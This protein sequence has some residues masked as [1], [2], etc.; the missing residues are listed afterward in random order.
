MNI[1]QLKEAEFNDIE[2]NAWMQKKRSLLSEAGFSGKEI[3]EYFGIK[4]FDRKALTDELTNIFQLELEYLPEKEEPPE[5]PKEGEK[6]KRKEPGIYPEKEPSWIQKF[7][8]I[9]EPAWEEKRAQAT[10]AVEAAEKTGRRPYEFEPTTEEVI[11][12]GF[13]ASVTGLLATGKVPEPLP[14]SAEKYMTPAQRILMQGSTLLGDL[15]FMTMG[16]LIG[17]G[18]GPVTAVGGVFALPA[19]LRKVLMDKY[20][21]G[22]IHSFS[23]FWKRLTDAVWETAKGEITGMATGAVGVRV[24]GLGRVPAE[25][26]TM[27]TVGDALEGQIPEPREFIDGAILIGGMRFS[28]HIAGKLRNIYWRSGKKPAEVIEDIKEDPSIKEDLFSDNKDVPD[29]YKAPEKPKLKRRFDIG[30]DTYEM[31]VGDEIKIVK[32]T[33]KGL[34]EVK[35][36]PDKYKKPEPAK[37]EI[38]KQRSDWDISR[39]DAEIAGLERRLREGEITKDVTTYYK[40]HLERLKAER[41]LLAELPTPE[42]VKPTATFRGWQETAEGDHIALYN[43]EGGKLDKSTV[44]LKTLKKEGIEVPETPEKPKIELKPPIEEPAPELKVSPEDQKLIGKF[45]EA[46][47]KLTSQIKEKREPAISKQALTARRARIA[48]SMAAD[49]DRLEQ[50]QNVMNGMADAIENRTLP[51]SL[52]GVT[53]KAQIETLRDFRGDVYPDINAINDW[54]ATQ[55]KRIKSA[56]IT[57]LEE[58]KQAQADIQAF[59]KGPS[60]EVLREKALKAKEAEFIGRKVPGFFP[61]PEPVGKMMVD[62]A[63]IEAGTTVL[64]PSAGMGNLAEVIRGAHPEA[65]LSV[66][67]W[68]YSLR[69]LLELK[70]FKVIGDDF[71]KHEGKYDRI[72]QNPPFEKGQDVDHVYHA[73]EHLN[74]GGRLI[75][76]MSEGPFFKTDKKSEAFRKWFEERKGTTYELEGAFKGAESFRQ[77]GVKS[78]IVMIDKPVEKVEKVPEKPEPKITGKPGAILSDKA[79]LLKEIDE[80]IKKAPEEATDI[81]WIKFKIDGATAKIAPW[82]D[83]L[84]EFR[85]RIQKTPEKEKIVKPALRK[86]PAKPSPVAAKREHI[87]ELIKLENAAGWFSDGN[88]IIKGEPPKNKKFT[89]FR[90]SADPKDVF[91]Q[92]DYDRTV[93]TERLYYYS[94]GIETLDYVVSKEPVARLGDAESAGVIFKCGD[95]YTAYMQD[96]FNVVRNRFPDAEYRVNPEDGMLVAYKDQKPVAGLMPFKPLEETKGPLYDEPP[97]KA[98]AEGYGLLSTDTVPMA[99]APEKGFRRK[100]EPPG[101]I[102]K[103]IRR[104]D[105]VNFL[106]EKLDVPIRTGRFWGA[107]RRYL[108]IFKLKEEVVRTKFAN[109][110]ET[111]CHEAGHGLQKFLWPEALTRQGLSSKPLEPWRKELLPIATKPRGGQAKLPEGFAEFIRLYVT[112]EKQALEKAPEFYKA[113]ESMLGE[114]SPEAKEILLETRKEF[115]KWIKQPA[116]MRVLSQVSIGAREKR[117]PRWSDLYTAAVDDLHF[118]KRVVEAMTRGEKIPAEK[119]PYK[120]ARLMR[121]WH[122]RAEHFLERSPYLFKTYENVGKPLRAIL[123]PVKDNLDEFRAFIVSKRAIELRNRGIETGVLSEDAEFVVNKYEPVYGELFKDLIK[124]QDATLAYLVDSGLVSTKTAIKMKKLNQD[125][126]PFYRIMETDRSRGTGV[127]LQARQ[128]IKRI[129]GSWRDIQDP[130][131][132]IIKNTY[133]YIN[134]AEKN[135]VGRALVNLAES[136]EGMGKYVERIPEPKQVIKIREPELWGLLQKYG[137]WVET[138]KYK[139]LKR[140]IEE[141]VRIGEGEELKPLDKVEERVREALTTRGFSKGETSQIIERLK[142][143]KTSEAKSKIIERTI[144]KVAVIETTKEFGLD[145]PEGV[146][147]IFRPS[148]FMPK[149]NVIA[150]WRA[151]KRTLYQVHPDVA[152]TML[153]LDRESV[154]LLIRILGMPAGWLRA[155]ATLTPEFIARNP[156]RDQFSAF[157]YSKYNFV[158]GYDLAKGIFSL[159]KKDEAYWQWK[160]GGGMRSML[161]SMDRKYLQKNLG[162]V[163]Q[164]TPV[165]NIIKNPIEA[166]RILSE[167]M[168]AAT[169]LGE[170]KKGIKKEGIT[171]TGMLE[172]GYASREVTLDFARV[173]AKTRAVNV[174][175]AF[176][177]ANVQGMSKMSRAFKEEPAMTTAKVAAGI[178]L[179]SVILTIVNRQD[180]RWKEIPQWQKDLFWIVMTENHIWRIPKPFELGILF[181]TVPERITEYILDQDPHAFD[182][183]IQAIVRGASPGMIP[184]VAI[185]WME[186]WANRSLFLDRPIV[187]AAR[188]KVLPE[189]QYKPYTT[190]V[191][192]LIGRTLGELPP[193]E[194]SPYISPAR[195]ENLI[196]GWSGGLGIHILKVADEALRRTGIVPETVKPARTWADIPLIKGFAVRHPSGQ[197]E[198]IKKFY[199][200][201]QDIEQIITTIKTLSKKELKY[202]EAIGILEE[203]AEQVAIRLTGIREGLSNAQ[204]TISFI[205]ENPEIPPD[206]KRQLIDLIYYQMIDMARGGNDIVEQVKK[207]AKEK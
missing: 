61:T 80:A 206:E 181:G 144:E 25:V 132:S 98:E 141:K 99:F 63:G 173:G 44:T 81:E 50:I 170:F 73:Y 41:E 33:P 94:T 31:K 1:E 178:T 13:K 77:T 84:K 39:Y 49:A 118:L 109:D 142:G 78:R 2:I 138:S 183:T 197:A 160:K 55:A 169:R 130:L 182:G 29:K 75:S 171:K 10:L 120:L 139:E 175:I 91:K 106:K 113:F 112:N 147:E 154:N 161:V 72:V 146:A 32:F 127:G 111:I 83:A 148:A 62:L 95:K 199:D 158:P 89:E 177:N 202:E 16:A 105:I 198:S 153:A 108:G 43:I 38:P 9:F 140:E 137:K 205:Y 128:P 101:E 30:K 64:E 54:I 135:A 20:E 65:P 149:D 203:N 48:G 110:I 174:L 34:E 40:P 56:N 47:D 195:I 66:L 150:V 134:L 124:Y 97:L 155:G 18:G 8:R 7:V 57:N 180:E 68:N 70:K 26:V 90:E 166:L 45:R 51:E 145:L 36:F 4:S 82:K 207:M 69:E 159:A 14:E 24:P 129:K 42:E 125:Y 117:L 196:R 191:A 19:G 200:N 100:P 152:K 37:I 167:T 27:V 157:A 189:Y 74:P 93:A 107:G 17:A 88:I 164:K 22:E 121:G 119:D 193:L 201:Y 204:K 59:I 176:W 15:P 76:V 46:A 143:A 151:G 60:E 52:K 190:E 172:A 168:E 79:G 136:T 21:K 12:K 71:L 126:V 163:L 116:E 184:T 67:E 123:E 187:P 165:R 185:P 115:D 3:D 179:P 192:K 28:T 35:E 87:E 92:M 53:N 156:F 58:L 186:N 162:Q 188:E 96:K 6:P 11:S 104:S 23:E 194:K 133:L 102:E 114:K 131:E 85:R 86:A 103:P 5:E 122:G